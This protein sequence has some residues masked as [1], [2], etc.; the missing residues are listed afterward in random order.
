MYVGRILNSVLRY[1]YIVLCMFQV[2]RLMESHQN[3]VDQLEMKIEALGENLQLCRNA[4]STEVNRVS[5]LLDS[6][7]K[8][9]STLE[10]GISY[11]RLIQEQQD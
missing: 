4:T 10:Q 9:R 6:Q 11:F 5:Y 2:L 7:K 8:C 1:M 3:Q